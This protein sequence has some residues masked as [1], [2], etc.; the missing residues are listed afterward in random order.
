MVACALSLRRVAFAI[1]M[2]SRE[3]SIAPP[4]LAFA[5]VIVITRHALG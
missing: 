5:S 1:S 2:K 4:A 3:R